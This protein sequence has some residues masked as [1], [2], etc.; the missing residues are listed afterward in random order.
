MRRRLPTKKILIA[1][2]GV[3]VVSYVVAC[4]ETQSS[5]GNLVAPVD[6]GQLDAKDDQFSSSG[7]LVAPPPI[8]AADEDV[9]TS[10][11]LVAPVDSGEDATADAPSDAPTDASND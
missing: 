4:G 1:A 2:V 10:G 7:N 5:S 9:S 6:G 3:G 8:D 11:N